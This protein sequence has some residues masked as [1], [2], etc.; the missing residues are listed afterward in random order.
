MAVRAS[1]SRLPRR[2]LSLVGLVA[3]LV[4]AARLW[5]GGYL[6][7]DAAWPFPAQGRPAPFDVLFF[8]GDAGMRF[9]MGPFIAQNFAAHGA[10]V[11]AISTSTLF[12]GG[13]TRAELDR[14]VADAVARAQAAAGSRRLIVIGQSYGADIVQAGL[15]HLPP[16]LRAKIAGVILIVP[17]MGTYFRADPTGLLYRFGPDRRSITT[18]PSIDWVPLTCIY[19][20]Q[21][22]DSVCPLLRM[23]NATVIRL[24]GD[25]YLRRDKPLLAATALEAA[26]RAIAKARD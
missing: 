15:A 13:R 14:I 12:R 5:S 19:G 1:R 9:G 16:P 17:G 24:P 23:G 18:V 10:A 26:R 7:R 2:L 11:T 8:S 21:E 6:D 20:A 25:H 3:I 4:L 22:E